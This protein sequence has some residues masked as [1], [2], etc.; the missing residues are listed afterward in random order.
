MMTRRRRAGVAADGA[1]MIQRAHRPDY[2][3]IMLVGLIML[4]GLVVIYAIGPQRSQVLN[5]L[6]GTSFSE[7]YFVIKQAISLIAAL[8]AL[9]VMA[10][11]PLK[12]IR[13][14][15]GKI[16]IGG[17]VAGA[18]L[19]LFGNVL[20]VEQIARC[21]LGACRWFELGPLGSFQASELLKFGILIFIARFLADRIRQGRVNDWEDTIAPL[22][23]V[24]AVALFMV[25]VLQKD[26]GT[27][28][29]MVAIIGSMLMVGGVNLR[30][31]ATLLA[32]LAVLAVLA[33]VS[34]PHRI[35]R[36]ATFLRGDETS[37]SATE[38]ADTY[39][40]HHAKIAMG[41]GGLFGVGIGN[42]VQATGYLPEAINDSVFAI[43]GETFGFVGLMVLMLLM[44]ALL[45]RILRITDRLQDDWMRL[46][47]AGL[48]G[49]LAAHIVLNIASMTGVF[50]LTGITLPLLSF[51]GTS[52]V[53]IGAA[54]GMVFQA[55]RYTS[56]GDLIRK[57]AYADTGRGRGIGR[58]RYAGR[59]RVA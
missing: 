27:G 28:L 46:I 10:F 36:V 52:M 35:E 13:Q 23:I 32:G 59:R 33:I 31:G 3:M 47:A 16:M 58:T 48:F 1:P 9:F 51:G 40:I 34:A 14:H 7:T 6:A 19:F 22:V 37:V 5:S 45:L 24:S 30:I 17:L 53:F 55:S 18:L 8:I 20:G 57:D 38:D 29:A 41:S 11:M 44:T 43:I 2:V 42:S 26:L 21:S 4:F 12:I 50:P 15:A 54:I 25:V 56:H 49:W 39:H